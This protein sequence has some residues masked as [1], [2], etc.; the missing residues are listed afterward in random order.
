MYFTSSHVKL[1][2][3]NRSLSDR[4]RQ[5]HPARGILPNTDGLSTAPSNAVQNCYTAVG[6]Y[7]KVILSFNIS[8]IHMMLYN[9]KRRKFT[10]RV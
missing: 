8:F 5:C 10:K 9:T 2:L 3:I 4:E 1:Q 7:S 6:V